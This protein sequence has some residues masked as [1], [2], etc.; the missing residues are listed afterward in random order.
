MHGLAHDDPKEVFRDDRRGRIEQREAQP[1]VAGLFNRDRELLDP[2]LPGAEYDGH[3]VFCQRIHPQGR[4]L[5]DG[6]ESLVS[7]GVRGDEPDPNRERARCRTAED[8]GDYVLRLTLVEAG[9]NVRGPVR[10]RDGQSWRQ[11]ARLLHRRERDED[12]EGSD[13][14]PEHDGDGPF[15]GRRGVGERE[16]STSEMGERRNGIAARTQNERCRQGNR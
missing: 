11:V 4:S 12:D 8:R 16:K 2:R 15:H 14:P 5:K 13:N 9:R 3:A 7:C 1:E 10:S 6:V